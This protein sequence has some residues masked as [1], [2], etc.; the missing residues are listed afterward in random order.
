MSLFFLPRPMRLSGLL[1]AMLPLGAAPLQADEISDS[2]KSALE[3][4][5]DGDNGYALDELD[6]ARQMLMSL[7]TEELGRFLPEAPD[8]WS[9]EVNPDIT[10]GLAMMGGGTAAEAEYYNDNEGMTLTL[11]ADNPIVASVSAMV[12]N[13]AA[14]GAKIERVQREKFMLQDDVLQGMVDGRIMVKAEGGSPEAMKALVEK[15]DFGA[16]RDFGR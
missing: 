5:E 6:Y 14:F 13:A 11:M 8:G 3:A 7:K 2:L 16:L 10:S 4:Y 15:I 1:L 9:K 12:A